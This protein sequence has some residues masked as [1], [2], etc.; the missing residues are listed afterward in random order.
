MMIYPFIVLVA[1]AA[2]VC[3]YTVRDIG[4]QKWDWTALASCLVVIAS[5]FTCLGIAIARY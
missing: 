5:L 1:A 3:G 4:N 2:Y